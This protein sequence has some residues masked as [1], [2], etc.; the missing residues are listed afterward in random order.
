MDAA[1]N[2]DSLESA[3]QMDQIRLELGYGLLK[4]V[5]DKNTKS[6]TE[7]IKTLRHQLAAEIGFILPSVRIQDNLQIGATEYSIKIKE[8]EAGKGSLRPNQLLAMNPSGDP[9]ELVGEST[10]DPAFGIPAM[11]FSID[12]RTTAEKKGYTIVPVETVLITHFS[13]IVKDNLPELLTYAET[14]KILE[15]LPPDH[16]KLLKE[17]VPSQVSYGTI[18]RVLHSL[19]RER[20]SIRDLSS[21]LEAIAEVCSSTTNVRSI[22]EHV[23]S[24]LA[25]QICSGYADANNILSVVHLSS[26][27]EKIFLESLYGEGENKQLT[28]SPSQLQDFITKTKNILDELG[29]KGNQPVLLTSSPIRF[30]VRNLI[31]RFH[32]LTPVLAQTEIH[33]RVRIKT[34]GHVD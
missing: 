10:Q 18:Q 2:P 31:E 25:R 30:H 17:I 6:L 29:S 19:L 28:I 20:V 27:W 14:R 26:E 11:W 12:Q 21:I 15:H 5:N 3:I 8:V 13:E 1:E 24:R 23:R 7:Q 34:I 16:D 9:I 22:S 4:M 32:P 33:P